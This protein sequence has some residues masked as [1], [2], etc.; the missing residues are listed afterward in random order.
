MPNIGL[1]NYASI[2]PSAPWS[3]YQTIYEFK[4][5]L[6]WIKGEHTI[7]T[8]FSYAYEIKFEPTNTNVFGAFN[9]NGSVTGD[10]F[11][12]FML[13]RAQSYNETDTVAFN[14]NRR[15]SFEAYIDDSFKISRRLTLNFGL[16]YS[17][18]PPAYEPD[19]RFRVFE[20]SAYDPSK[21]VTLNDRGQIIRGTGDRKWT[22]TRVDLV[23]GSNSQLRAIAEVYACDDAQGAFVRDFVAAWDKVMNLDRFDLA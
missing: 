9:F 21:A 17:Y 18:F 2:S 19:D 23:F 10:A 20:P 16:R 22:G 8:G 3:N 4:D 6:T 5:N 12:D 15:N 7:K 11:A 1:V 14:D 13:G